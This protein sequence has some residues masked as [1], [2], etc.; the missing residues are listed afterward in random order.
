MA[1]VVRRPTDLVAR[2]GGEEFAIILGGTDAE[3]ALN[4]AEQVVRAVRS[5]QIPHPFSPTK[6]TLTLSV[7]ISTMYPAVNDSQAD[8]MREADEALYK[9]KAEG[10]DQIRLYARTA[11]KYAPAAAVIDDHS[12]V[13]VN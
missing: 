13:H 11:A 12:D 3:G 9:A 5:L 10:R 7:G 1:A 8:L 2:F 4:V 6:K